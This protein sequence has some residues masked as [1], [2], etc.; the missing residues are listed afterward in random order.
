MSQV[1]IGIEVAGSLNPP[2]S[3]CER[4]VVVRNVLSVAGPSP[5]HIVRTVAPE[6]IISRTADDGFNHRP[7]VD[8]EHTG[9]KNPPARTTYPA[10]FPGHQRDIERDRKAGKIQG[11]ESGPIPQERPL[12]LGPKRIEG[13]GVERIDIVTVTLPGRRTVEILQGGDVE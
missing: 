8:R 11:V 1:T 13:A 10:E 2:R 9:I 4:Y 6:D 12:P 7:I 5:Q 3:R